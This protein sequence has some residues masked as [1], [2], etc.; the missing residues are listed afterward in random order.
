MKQFKVY[1]MVFFLLVGSLT[2]GC[3]QYVKPDTIPVGC[4]N[5]LVYKNIPYADVVSGVIVVT[6]YE[7]FK[8][9]KAKGVDVAPVLV[10]VKQ[11]IVTLSAANLTYPQLVVAMAN[12]SKYIKDYA[13]VEMTIAA[14]LVSQMVKTDLTINV[15]DRSYFVK[16]LEQFVSMLALL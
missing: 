4:E 12:M 8:I 15:C 2:V 7:A 11:T 10:A 16:T 1:M 14:V 9:A 5:S 3:S 13:G 6:G